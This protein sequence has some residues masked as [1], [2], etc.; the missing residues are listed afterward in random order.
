MLVP[1]SYEYL[2]Q[3]M[4]VLHP[5]SAFMWDLDMKL[6]YGLALLGTFSAVVAIY[7]SRGFVVVIRIAAYLFSLATVS[8]SLKVLFVKHAFNFPK[9][10]SVV[11]FVSTLLVGVAVLG[12]RRI[13]EKKEIR[14]P[15]LQ[16]FVSIIIPI[17]V[18]FALSVGLHN[19]A[20]LYASA[21]FAEMIGCCTPI[22]VVLVSTAIG[23]R[24]DTRL[25]V[26]ILVVCVGIVLCAKGQVQYSSS[27]Q[28]SAQRVS[29]LGF[30]FAFAACVF[31]AVKS[32]L[33]GMLLDTPDLVRHRDLVMLDPLELL[34]WMSLPSIAIM[35][36]WSVLAE[37]KAPY[38]AATRSDPLPLAAALG[39]TCVLASGVNVLG[40]YMLKDIGVL[41]SQIGGQLKSILTVMGGVTLLGESVSSV[42]VAGFTCILAGVFWYNRLDSSRRAKEAVKQAS[43]MQALEEQRVANERTTLLLSPARE[44]RRCT[45]FTRQGGHFQCW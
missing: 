39:L 19:E 31:R 42:Q 40:L 25:L 2:H 30:A 38:L 23:Q 17:S 4:Q 34:L 12:Y 45:T 33:Q 37:G 14:V 1:I 41:G 36:V 27:G 7:I 21:G 9:C 8:I 16:Q 11:H 32:V 13:A 6:A 29:A 24:F 28:Q 22:C 15:P 18:T 43:G 35:L 20:L 44:T 26:P 5:H 10:V 3:L